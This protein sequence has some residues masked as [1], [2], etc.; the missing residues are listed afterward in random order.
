MG[1]FVTMMAE[2]LATIIN[3]FLDLSKE[4]W[5]KILIEIQFLTHAQQIWNIWKTAKN[6]SYYK[7]YL[8]FEIQR[9]LLATI[10]VIIFRLNSLR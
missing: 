5:S 10:R 3:E 6:Y 9:F 2:H 8:K 4:I 1:P 7:N